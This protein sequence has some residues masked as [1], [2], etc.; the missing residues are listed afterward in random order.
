MN[1]LSI[2]MEKY[3]PFLSWIISI[4][5]LSSPT[6]IIDCS[7]MKECQNTTD[8]EVFSPSKINSCEI[9]MLNFA[10][11]RKLKKHQESLSCIQHQ[12]T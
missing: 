8:V 5:E 3:K 1:A 11:Q 9:C 7:E 12:I 10:S 4:Q 6:I 2:N